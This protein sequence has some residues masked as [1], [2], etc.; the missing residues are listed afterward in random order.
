MLK[1]TIDRERARPLR[2]GRLGSVMYLRLEP[3]VH[4][5]LQEL[6]RKNEQTMASLLRGIVAEWLNSRNN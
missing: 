2:E 4:A 5:R 3:A 6:A 1:V